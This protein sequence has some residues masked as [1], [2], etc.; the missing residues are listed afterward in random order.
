MLPS[1][2]PPLPLSAFISPAANQFQGLIE[3]LHAAGLIPTQP[4]INLFHYLS[5]LNFPISV[6]SLSE[7]SNVPLSTTYRLL[8]SFNNHGLAEFIV[9]KSLTQRWFLIR[10]GN[11]NACSSCGQPYHTGY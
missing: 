9:D 8:K 3:A 2:K 7:G 4:C 11:N 5:S 1:C 6:T 10:S